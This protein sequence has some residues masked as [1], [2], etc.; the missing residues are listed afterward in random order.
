[1][2]TRRPPF[3]RIAVF[4]GSSP[5]DDPIYAEAARQF[6]QLL[7]ER[8]FDLVY[9]GGNVGLMGILADT[10]MEGDR[11]VMG[12]ITLALVDREVAHRG[13]TRLEEVET[14]HERKQRMY[15]L[16]DAAVALPG[17]IGTLDE[18]FEALTWNQLGYLAEPCGLLNV[19]GYFDPLV[20]LL[21]HMVGQGFLSIEA[22]RLLRVEDDAGRLLDTLSELRVPRSEKWIRGGLGQPA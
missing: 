19:N 2:A 15:D 7:V 6:G 10:V 20:E 22:R 9:G 12:V 1:M 21:D 3:R 16:A 18:L 4:C 8:G 13:I 17:G 14:M 5:G 11:E